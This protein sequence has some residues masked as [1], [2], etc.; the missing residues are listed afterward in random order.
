MLKKIVLGGI[1]LTT[2]FWVISYL[3]HSSVESTPRQAWTSSTDL[4]ALRIGEA[5]R[6]SREMLFGGLPKED[7]TLPTP[8]KAK[9]LR[10]KQWQ[11]KEFEE[12]LQKKTKQQIK[13]ELGP[14]DESNGDEW[15]YAGMRILNPDTEKFD[16]R[17]RLTYSTLFGS[18]GGSW[19]LT[20]LR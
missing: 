1:F 18:F 20:T 13:D 19:K 8:A 14:P 12:W 10:E 3:E 2:G 9:P 6:K 15:T 16:T 4:E 17:V 7:A 11:R 5:A